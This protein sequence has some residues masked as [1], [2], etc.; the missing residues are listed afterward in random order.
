EE[1]RRDGPREDGSHGTRHRH[2]IIRSDSLLAMERAVPVLPADDLAVAKRFYVDGLGFRV[3]FEASDDGKAGLPG[4]ERGGIRIT[5]DSPMSGHGR[6]ACVS[7]EV[8]SADAYY[9]EWRERV[10][11]KRPPRNEFWGARTFDV[12]DPFGNTIFVMGPPTA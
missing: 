9:D 6:D 8:D 10:E 3:T 7:L 12:I 2:C 11:V 1:S 5:L 4:V